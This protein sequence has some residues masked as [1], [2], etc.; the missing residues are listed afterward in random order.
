M[1][2]TRGDAKAVS[3][4]SCVISLKGNHAAVVSC[5]LLVRCSVRVVVRLDRSSFAEG[6]E[7]FALA[8]LERPKSL[9]VTFPA[10][11]VLTWS[12]DKR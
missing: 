12:D 8:A 2:F 11:L 4:L 7:A 3:I 10:G 5:L 9:I 1:L 6:A